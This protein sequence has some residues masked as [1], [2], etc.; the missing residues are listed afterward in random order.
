VTDR[1]LGANKSWDSEV[2]AEEDNLKDWMTRALDGDAAAYHSLLRRVTPL[3]RAFFKRRLRAD[4]ETEDLVQESLMALH[5]KRLTF[6]RKRPFTP[7]LYAIARYKLV[8]H[9]RRSRQFVD[10]NALDQV[11]GNGDFESASV[12]GILLTELLAD[13]TP[14]QQRAIRAT[15]IEGYSIAETAMAAG[16]SQSD[17]KMSV[18]R[19][20]KR[21]AA[22]LQGK[23]Q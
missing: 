18:S 3:L 19:G 5:S 1:S 15:K 23:P 13:L 6:D 8:D 10:L 17:T 9:F 21:M 20:L 2:T 14:K 16:I 12:A 4:S 7:W 11:P 22:R